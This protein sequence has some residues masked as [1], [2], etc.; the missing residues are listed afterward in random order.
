MSAYPRE[1]GSS[2]SPRAVTQSQASSGFV[3]A[4]KVMVQSERR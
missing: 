1:G 4:V 3:P 2:R